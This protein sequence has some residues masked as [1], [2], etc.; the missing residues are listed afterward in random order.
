[1][2]EEGQPSV[3]VRGRVPQRRGHEDWGPEWLKQKR[4]WE[5]EWECMGVHLLS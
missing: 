3:P 5:L 4:V 2:K 1:M